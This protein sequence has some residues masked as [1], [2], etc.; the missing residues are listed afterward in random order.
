[1]KKTLRTAALA[2]I[3]IGVSGVAMAECPPQPKPPAIP[4]DGSKVTGKEMTEARPKGDK[5]NYV[6]A[7]AV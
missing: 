5:A 6:K 3:M 7:E 2:A 1:M 4:A